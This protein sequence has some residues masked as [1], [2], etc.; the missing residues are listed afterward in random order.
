MV[1]SLHFSWITLKF[2]YCV[3]SCSATSGRSPRCT[4]SP[5]LNASHTSLKHHFC[6]HRNINYQIFCLL[7]GDIYKHKWLRSFHE[8]RCRTLKRFYCL[9]KCEYLITALKRFLPSKLRAQCSKPECIE[10]PENGKTFLGIKLQKLKI[11][12]KIIEVEW[13][14]ISPKKN[15]FRRVFPPKQRSK[16]AC[17]I[18]F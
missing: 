17:K 6:L 13:V 7:H 16:F 9:M 14:K 8:T 1:F 4:H 5:Q 10:S 18:Q 2:C 11:K 15:Q 12:K 3:S